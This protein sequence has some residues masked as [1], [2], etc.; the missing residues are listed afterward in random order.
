[1][2]LLRSSTSIFRFCF[3]LSRFETH[4]GSRR[5]LKREPS[6]SRQLRRCGSKFKQR[7][8][9]RL[10]RR[11]RPSSQ[12]RGRAQNLNEWRKKLSDT[13]FFP[14]PCRFSSEITAE[15]RA[16]AL[17]DNQTRQN[18]ISQLQQKTSVLS[19]DST[20]RPLRLGNEKRTTK[21]SHLRRQKVK[22]IK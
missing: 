8:V 22:Q 1:M 20:C 7:D 10:G 17:L 14:R 9:L 6:K 16:D 15:S 3:F 5:M 11:S 18:E 2:L 12:R 21:Q 4:H 13:P 19:A